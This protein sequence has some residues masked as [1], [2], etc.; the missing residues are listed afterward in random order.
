MI[1]TCNANAFG[2]NIY[3]YLHFFLT[4]LLF[5][6]FIKSFKQYNLEYKIS[7]KKRKSMG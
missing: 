4:L 2:I 3:K 1:D 6:D 7:K 5:N